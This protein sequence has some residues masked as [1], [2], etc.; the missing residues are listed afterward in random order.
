MGPVTPSRTRPK[1]AVVVL[2]AT[3]ALLIVATIVVAIYRGRRGANEMARY[4]FVPV[5]F[6]EDLVQM[7]RM[8]VPD[9]VLAI[10]LAC[11]AAAELRRQKLAAVLNPL[12]YSLMMVVVVWG[13][14]SAA[15][16][17]RDFESALALILAVPSAL[18]P[19]IG[20]VL[21]RREI[22]SNWRGFSGLPKEG[23]R[24]GRKS[25]NP[26]TGNPGTGGT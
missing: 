17:P 9:I 7:L 24:S 1:I 5:P 19:I 14:I 11:G 12:V 2:N 10:I 4:G 18:P 22:A 23:P 15:L 20:L 16:S 8:A 6:G 25:G 21:Y 26:G 3:V 13:A